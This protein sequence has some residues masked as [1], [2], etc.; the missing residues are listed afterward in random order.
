MLN[1]T[2]NSNFSL[3]PQACITNCFFQHPKLKLNP[4]YIFSPQISIFILSLTTQ[5]SILEPGYHLYLPLFRT[6]LSYL[7]IS[8]PSPPHSCHFFFMT[9]IRLRNVLLVYLCILLLF[10]LSNITSYLE[11]IQEI[12]LYT[13]WKLFSH[14]IFNIGVTLTSVWTRHC[15]LL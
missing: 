7:K 15:L 6:V 14:N 1:S 11:Y 5:F 4:W 2:V 8:I 12:K 9:E 13:Q 10:G 3:E